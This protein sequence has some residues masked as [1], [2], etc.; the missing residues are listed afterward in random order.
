MSDCLLTF[1][2]TPFTEC[3]TR[4]SFECVRCQSQFAR[5]SPAFRPLRESRANSVER[6]HRLCYSCGN[7]IIGLTF[8]EAVEYSEN[9]IEW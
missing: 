8:C 7:N 9:E 5:G 6:W 1:R 2:H 3:R 4:K